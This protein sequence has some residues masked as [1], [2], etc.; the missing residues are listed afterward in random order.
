MIHSNSP[1]SESELQ[2]RAEHIAGLT[3]AELAQQLNIK[4]PEN[5]SIEKGWLGQLLELALGA[6]A[7][8]KA[9]PDFQALGIELKTLPLNKE[10]RAKESTFVCSAT[11]APTHFEESLV[12]QKLR[13]VLWI[14]F[15]ADP[16][17][18]FPERRIGSPIFWSP[19]AEQKTIVEQ[20]W[21][22]LT[23]MLTLGHYA[24]LSAK[25]G[26]YLQLRPKAA[27]SQVLRPHINLEGNLQK[28][29]PRGFYLR[30]TLTNMILHPQE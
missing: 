29:V 3:F 18:P 10:H 13:R 1:T 27:H 22:E 14:P 2:Q 6:T 15:E 30:T 8:S 28:M 24:N 16:T 21:Q 12:Y 25:Y 20:D 7:G 5:L 11:T 26:T 4:I 19:T 17:L 23:E 9:E